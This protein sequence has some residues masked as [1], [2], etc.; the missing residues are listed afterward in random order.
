MLPEALIGRP[1]C[2]DPDSALDA[3]IEI[4]RLRGYD[5]ASV[6]S[7]TE[8]MGIS[9][10]SMYQA[11]GDKH[12]LYVKALDRY[13]DRNVSASV[14]VL[15]GEGGLDAIDQIFER[16]ARGLHAS[17]T[18]EPPCLIYR[19]GVELAPRDPETAQRAAI[20][21]DRLHAAYAHALRAAI[22]AGDLSG[23][24]PVER[25]AWSLV[26]LQHG[27]LSTV[28]SPPDAEV[29]EQAPRALLEPYRAR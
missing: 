29:I 18:D 25:L 15:E 12:E 3:A 10:A 17:A 20:V 13:L 24:A 9:R 28:G 19:C 8:A 7:L 22:D 23:E 5:G 27:A 1:R 4:F 26:F 14:A 16:T 2:F 11:F 21:R 6:E